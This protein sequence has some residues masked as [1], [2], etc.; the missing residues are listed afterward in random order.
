MV[1]FILLQVPPAFD[2]A[3]ASNLEELV[4]DAITS[5]A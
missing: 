5:L 2:V 3:V 4:V 1:E